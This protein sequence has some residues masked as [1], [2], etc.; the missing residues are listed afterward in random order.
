MKFDDLPGLEWAIDYFVQWFSWNFL[1]A[2]L[3]NYESTYRDPLSNTFQDYQPLVTAQFFI[4]NLSA[5]E[6]VIFEDPMFG[7][8]SCYPTNF[9]SMSKAIQST[10]VTTNTSGVMTLQ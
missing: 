5:V 1:F 3:E 8:I 2:N 9:R 7:K 10:P 4:H 6:N